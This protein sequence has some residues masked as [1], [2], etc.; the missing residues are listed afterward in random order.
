VGSGRTDA[1]VHATGQ[2]AHFD[3]SWQRADEALLRALNAVLPRDIAG[4]SLDR[5]A[6]DFHARFDAIARSYEYTFWLRPQRSPLERRRTVQIAQ[7]LDLDRM[8]AAA[9]RFEGEHDF[10]VF[11]RPMRPEGSTHRTIFQ[12]EI[13]AA[14]PKAYYRVQA[15]AFLRHQVRR[16]VG[17]LVD[18]GRGAIEAEAITSALAGNSDAVRPRRVPPQGLVLVAVTYPPDVDRDHACELKSQLE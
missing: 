12:S 14:G 11:G 17:A 15:N 4:L 10:G 2:V 18:V 7:D 5:A 16:M 13:V 8:A 3:S 9:R 1:G 6:S